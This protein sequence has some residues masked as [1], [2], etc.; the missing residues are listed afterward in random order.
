MAALFIPKTI[1]LC[2]TCMQNSD[3]YFTVLSLWRNILI[4]YLNHFKPWD[5]K[6]W[7]QGCVYLSLNNSIESTGN[8]E[9][10]THF[11]VWPHGDRRLYRLG[12]KVGYG[13]GMNDTRWTKHS[14]TTQWSML[15]YSSVTVAHTETRDP[16]TA[17]T[18]FSWLP[19]PKPPSQHF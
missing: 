16:V 10:D 1:I 18:K 6:I 14:I 2:S 9:S 11:R 4:S 19:F 3:N 7:I 5:E 15:S 13:G 12:I 17:D 8:H